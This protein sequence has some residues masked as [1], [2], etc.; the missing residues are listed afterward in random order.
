MCV[1]KKDAHAEVKR[2][3]EFFL[4]YYEQNSDDGHMRC[5]DPNECT[6]KRRNGLEKKEHGKRYSDVVF[7]KNLNI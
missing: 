7:P 1:H 4:D 6:E 2:E 5:T 3:K